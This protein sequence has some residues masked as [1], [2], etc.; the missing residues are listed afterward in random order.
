MQKLYIYIYIFR[1]DTLIIVNDKKMKDMEET[2]TAYFK[3][4]F[5]N[6]QAMTEET[7][8]PNRKNR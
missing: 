8:S 5:L 7:G 6:L 2:V 4:F 1:R 3:I